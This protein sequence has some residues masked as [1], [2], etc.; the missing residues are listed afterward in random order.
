[1]QWEQEKRLK[2]GGEWEKLV[3]ND[4]GRVIGDF[5]GW[6]VSIES[7]ET[8][9]TLAVGSS[10]RYNNSAGCRVFVGLNVLYLAAIQP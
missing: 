1:M 9:E 3:M 8:Q 6:L 7:L 10:C 4:C 5:G 2:I